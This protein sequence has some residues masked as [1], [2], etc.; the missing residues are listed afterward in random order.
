ML[1][2]PYCLRKDTVHCGGETE[3]AGHVVS[4]VRKGRTGGSESD[5]KTSRPTPSDSLPPV[6]PYLLKVA[7]PPQAVPPDGGP[8]IQT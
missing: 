5:Y 4:P 8:S 2:L 6:L 3:A 1:I 7:Q